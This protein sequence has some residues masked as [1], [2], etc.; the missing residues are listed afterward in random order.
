[1][2]VVRHG[3]EVAYVVEWEGRRVVALLFQQDM[4]TRM[5]PVIFLQ[6]GLLR[7]AQFSKR[8]RQ[9]LDPVLCPEFRGLHSYPLS[10]GAAL[11]LCIAILFQDFPRQPSESVLLG[12]GEAKISAEPPGIPS[13]SRPDF[14]D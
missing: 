13:P 10:L 3:I 2:A 7:G 6:V 4:P 8:P 12:Y 9:A 5:L 14:R 11:P 1:M